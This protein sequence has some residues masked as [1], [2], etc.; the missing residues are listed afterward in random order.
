[1]PRVMLLVVYI[2]KTLVEVEFKRDQGARVNRC[3]TEN[4]FKK[5]GPITRAEEVRDREAINIQKVL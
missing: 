4:L 1:M 2:S 5:V 3:C